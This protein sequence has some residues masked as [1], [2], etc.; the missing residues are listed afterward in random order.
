MLLVNNKLV[1]FKTISNFPFVSSY[2][3]Y[4]TDLL[5]DVIETLKHIYED[6]CG[7]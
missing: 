7:I 6:V 4:F 5:N 2:V 1:Y 3:M